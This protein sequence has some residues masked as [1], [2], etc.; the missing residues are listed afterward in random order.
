MHCPQHQWGFLWV[1]AGSGSGSPQPHPLHKS[2][3]AV[4]PI[5]RIGAT[6][7]LGEH[8]KNQFFTTK[9]GWTTLF[10]GRKA[11]TD[12][13]NEIV[14]QALKMLRLHLC[15]TGFAYTSDI[16]IRFMVQ[17]RR[18]G[19]KYEHHTLLKP[20]YLFFKKIKI[21]FACSLHMKL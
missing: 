17:R 14:R 12:P 16:A 3:L 20:F 1:A 9:L 5:E 8:N 18:V 6:F 15:R 19:N 2:I 11:I 13:S 10:L 4:I 21:L 7:H